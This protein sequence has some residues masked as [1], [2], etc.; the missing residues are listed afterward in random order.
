MRDYSEC[1]AYVEHLRSEHKQIHQA[2]V[3]VERDLG[4]ADPQCDSLRMRDSLQRLN[5][6]L[7]EHFAEEEQGGCL[8]EAICYDPRLSPDVARIEKE[9]P[10]ILKLLDRL[11]GRSAECHTPDFHV[12]FRQFAQTLHAHESAENRILHTAFGTG[13]FEPN[14]TTASYGEST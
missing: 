6:T 7:A 12:S 5:E 9:H 11:I 14:D 13:E 1:Q 10:D 4:A 8:E 2:L 3:A